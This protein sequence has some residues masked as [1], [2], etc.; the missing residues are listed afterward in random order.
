M[1]TEMV[2][3]VFQKKHLHKFEIWFVKTM[4]CNFW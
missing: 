1:Q 4:L 2:W 3:E